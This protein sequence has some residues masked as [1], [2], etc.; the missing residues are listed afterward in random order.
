MTEIPEAGVWLIFLL[1]LLSFV[2][3][4]FVIRPFLNNKALYAGYLTI[5]CIAVSLALALWTLIS[6]NSK[7]ELLFET[8]EWAVIGSTNINIGVMVDS[9]TAVMVVVI[10]ICS[11]MVQIYSQ[12]Y[13]HGDSG[14]CRYYAFM[15]LFT[16]SML[17]LVLADNLVQ[18]YVFWELVGLCSYLLIGFWFHRPSAAAAAKKAFLVTRL[19]DFGFLAAIL[20]LYFRAG[21]LDIAELHHLA[22]TGVLAG[23]VLTWAA[24]GIFSGAVGKSAQFPLHVWLPD[25]MEGP[26][27]VSALIHSSTMVTAGVFLV[28]RCF[29]IFASSE[30]ALTVVAA[31][32]AFTA[33]FAASM[34]L[35][36]NDI[37]RVLAY[38]TISQLGYMM[39]GLG[40]VGLV[41]YPELIHE[42]AEPLHAAN[43]I[44]FLAIFHLFNHAFAKALLFLAAGS[45]NHATGTF[46]MRE[47]GGLRQ[48][49]R[50]TYLV[51][52]IATISIAGIWPL[53]CFWSKDE[54]VAVASDLGGAR[55]ILF[56][57]AM[58]TVFMTAF[59]MFRTVYMTFHGEYRGK[60][61]SHGEH[62]G[63]GG[64]HESPKVMLIPM[65]ILAALAV[66]SGWVN[67]NGWF[68]RFFGEHIDQS[69]AFFVKVFS[70]GYLPVASLIIAL[71]GVGF[72]YA[73]YIRT[74]PSAE[75]IGRRFSPLYTLFSRKYWM[76]E[77]YERFFVV[78]VLVD[79]IFWF[80]HLFDTYVVDGIVNGI[81][82][83]TIGG[84]RVIRR[85]QTGR[86]Q[87][88][89]LI[90]FVGILVIVG[91]LYLFGR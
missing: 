3:I 63:H 1:P 25:A 4:S 72:A 53:A 85:A 80:L 27:P 91:C 22:I 16:A 34:A 5:G 84:G 50:W 20:Y 88:Y 14:Y 57:L 59:Y 33:I 36:A 82:G 10:T 71:L 18:L 13:M 70:H 19:G 48:H 60:A 77:L 73:V 9:L 68:G 2:V 6:V 69:G 56:Y 8:H 90:M 61:V 62:G 74:R 83:G 89:G 35:V 32:G 58:I 38:C 12:G 67:I 37:K 78:R 66:G 11:L 15:S 65:F 47:M 28:A 75:S 64:L 51:Y 30:M 54:I 81:A 52:L 44:T 17:G 86:L 23:G 24:I 40:A 43:A 76:D 21:T 87:A 79:G 42:G 46:D 29:P 39:L 41:L 7:G 55:S 31:I 49:M 26:T 45:V